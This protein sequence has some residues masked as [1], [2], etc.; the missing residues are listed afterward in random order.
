M[1]L[2]QPWTWMLSVVLVVWGPSSSICTHQPRQSTSR[3]RAWQAVNQLASIGF[4]A[5]TTDVFGTGCGSVRS[6]RRTKRRRCWRRFGWNIPALCSGLLLRTICMRSLWCVGRP[7]PTRYRTL[8]PLRHPRLPQ[9]SRLSL[10]HPRLPQRSRLSLRHPRLPQRSRLSLRHPRLPQQ[11]RLSLRH[12]R[13]RQ[14]L[15]LWLRHLRLRQRSWLSL[16]HLRQR[17]QLRLWLRH[18]R[19]QQQ[20]R[21]SLRR[22]RL[23]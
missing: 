9:R 17:R 21:L 23:R 2:I 4:S 15:R 19:L 8:T 12:P 10:R 22:V 18:R 16:R 13:Q 14:Q 11:L 5:S 6:R 20:L 3:S 7:S 1:I